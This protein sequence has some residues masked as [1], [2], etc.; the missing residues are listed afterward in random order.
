MLNKQTTHPPSSGPGGENP[1]SGGE[2]G[3]PA[4]R[5]TE[6]EA[7]QGL[8][9]ANGRIDRGRVGGLQPEGDQCDG[10]REG[11]TRE[12]VRVKSLTLQHAG[13]WLNHVSRLHCPGLPGSA[14][15]S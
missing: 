8:Q 3:A 2:G 5:G 13:A 9:E 10:G 11:N 15:V 14:E 7:G 4:N 6:R 1:G 12:R